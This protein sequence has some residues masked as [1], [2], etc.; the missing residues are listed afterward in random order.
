[1]DEAVVG[2]VRS[3]WMV[4]IESA[5][6]ENSEAVEEWREAFMST[7]TMLYVLLVER[8]EDAIALP[9]PPAPPVIRTVLLGVGVG[10]DMVSN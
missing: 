2:L 1:M 8:K 7:M 10:D 6:N 9:R 3:A 5:W 4:W